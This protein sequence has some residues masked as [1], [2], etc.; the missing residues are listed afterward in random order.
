M[1]W[2]DIVTEKEAIKLASTNPARDNARDQ[3]T[4]ATDA[5]LRGMRDRAW[6]A[7]DR[8]GYIVAN[9]ILAHRKVVKVISVYD[10]VHYVRRE[11]FNNTGKVLLKCCH[12]DG[13]SYSEKYALERYGY[14][15]PRLHRD[16]IKTVLEGAE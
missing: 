1:N 9:S 11:D 2:T 16:N 14:T 7:N 4:S 5:E 10:V 8:T 3:L 6:L 15:Q 13:S 12:K